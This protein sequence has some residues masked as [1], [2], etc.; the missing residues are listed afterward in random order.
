MDLVGSGLALVIL[1]P[2]F[3]VIAIAIKST[4][5]GPVFFR[6]KRVGQHGKCFTFLKFRSMYVNNDASQHRDYVRQLISGKAERSSDGDGGEGVFKLTKDSRI[7]S[8]GRFLRRTSLDELPQFL[9]VMIGEMS[10]VGPRP[11]IPY[12]VEAYDIWHRRRVLEAKPGITGLWQV[13]GRSRVAFDEMVRLDLRYAQNWSPWLD[14]KIL[15]QTPKAVM[16]GSGA[17]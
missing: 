11:A 7:T 4:S 5:R 12:E 2:L 8:T 1:A 15:A 9:N 14:L 10:L 16:E 13:E 3:L 6:Q 17:Y